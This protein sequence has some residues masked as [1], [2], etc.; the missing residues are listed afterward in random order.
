MEEMTAYTF[1]CAVA[2]FL[3]DNKAQNIKILNISSVSSFADYFVIASSDTSTQIKA[4]TQNT[5]EA[6]KKNFG[7]IPTGREDDAKNKWNLLDYGDVVIHILQN[8][9][10]ESYAIEKFWYHAYSID[11]E[12]WL[13]E[14]KAFSKYD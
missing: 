12:A 2:R 3:D 8:T 13:E 4:L 6:V 10:R 9:E 11:R 5:A 7:R 1:A 14:S